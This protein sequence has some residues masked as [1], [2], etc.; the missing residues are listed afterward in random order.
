MGEFITNKDIILDTLMLK[1]TYGT[2][3]THCAS[4]AAGTIMDYK[5]KFTGKYK[6]SG[7]LGDM[8]HGADLYLSS[9]STT[10]QQK[11]KYPDIKDEIIEINCM[12][13][14]KESTTGRFPGKTLTNTDIKDIIRHSSVTDDFTKANPL[15]YGAGKIDA[16]KGL[17]YVLGLDK[18][19][20]GELP[21]KHIGA[22]LDGRTLIIN[23]NPDVQVSIYN[24][25]GQKV[26]DAQVVSGTVELPQ[27]PAGVYAVK[28][29]SEG[30]TLIRL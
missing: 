30:S 29:G 22:K 1:D 5:D 7:K 21:T 9:G 10:E 19:A 8:A 24:L 20:I 25:S 18:T 15:R 14:A 28:I 13:A 17:N 3:G 16:Y 27:L 12:Q 26:F 4:I 23:G 11:K 2:H 6:D